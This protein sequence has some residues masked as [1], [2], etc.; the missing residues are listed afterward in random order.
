M[1]KNILSHLEN[2]ENKLSV[3]AQR[4]FEVY[5]NGVYIKSL[6]CFSFGLILFIIFSLFLLFISKKILKSKKEKLESIFYD[7]EYS[8]L[9]GVGVCSVFGSI[10]LIITGIIMF[11]TSVLGIFAPDYVAINELIEGVKNK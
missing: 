2:L 1:D 4:G 7:I 5:T 6:L 10:I 8:T 9:S 3:T 11:T